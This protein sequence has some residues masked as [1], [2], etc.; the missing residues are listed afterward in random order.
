MPTSL[1]KCNKHQKSV[2]QTEKYFFIF[3]GMQE[4]AYGVNTRLIDFMDVRGVLKTLI[5]WMLSNTDSS[6]QNTDLGNLK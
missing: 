2:S 3:P 1:C 6:I 4:L 5:S